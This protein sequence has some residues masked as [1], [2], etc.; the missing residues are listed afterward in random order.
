MAGSGRGSRAAFARPLFGDARL[1][2]EVRRGDNWRGRGVVDLLPAI[3]PPLPSTWRRRL[4]ASR[5]SYGDVCPPSFGSITGT[6]ARST[7]GLYLFPSKF[8][9]TPARV[10]LTR[11]IKNTLTCN[12]IPTRYILI[13]FTFQYI[14]WTRCRLVSIKIKHN[15]HEKYNIPD[16]DYSQ[17]KSMFHE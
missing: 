9:S 15:R 1:R 5:D 4:L 7:L 14:T 3:A 16:A 10:S 11:G 12:N 6:L 2:R 13:V 8:A 17:C